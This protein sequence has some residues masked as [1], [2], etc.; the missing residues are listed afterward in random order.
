MGAASFSQSPPAKHR[1]SKTS[2]SDEPV[3]ITDF[4]AILSNRTMSKAI[5][6]STL[7]YNKKLLELFTLR[8]NKLYAVTISPKC[9]RLTIDK[10]ITRQSQ[11]LRNIFRT[12]EEKHNVKYMMFIEIY[13][14]LENIH[15]H[16]FME[17]N[18]VKEVTQVKKTLFELIRQRKREAKE[19]YKPLLDF[20]QQGI[21]N[22][23]VARWT[24]YILKEQETNIREF[25][26]IHNIQH[27]NN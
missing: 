11:L 10:D 12:V 13:K 18:T 27:L 21:D 9:S 15:L 7:D 14:D 16:G 3:C 4:F 8:N 17:I 6:T 24:K 19:T 20:D 26:P 23:S 1:S 2:K 22:E 25:P 5:D